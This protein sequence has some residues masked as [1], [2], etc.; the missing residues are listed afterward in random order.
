LSKKN[1]AVT[2]EGSATAS[3][4]YPVL[5]K[6]SVMALSLAIEN[7]AVTAKNVRYFVSPTIKKLA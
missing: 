2:A 1:L 7:Y 6:M 3:T 5:W 4:V